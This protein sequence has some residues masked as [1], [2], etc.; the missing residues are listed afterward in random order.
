MKLE[1]IYI[2]VATPFNNG[3]IDLDGY[4]KYVESLIDSGIAGVVV[5][6]STGESSMLSMEE[7]V[8][9]LKFTKEFVNNRIQVI[10]NCGANSTS[11]AIYLTQEA[12][13]LEVD[14]VLS[15]VPYYVKPTQAG[16]YQHFKSI[17]DATEKVPIIIYNVP[18]RT[19]TDISVDTVAELAKLDRMIGIKE[20]SSDMEKVAEMVARTPEDFSVLS[21]NDAT[22]LPLLAVGGKGVIS[23]IGNIMPKE[24]VEL[25]NE[26]MAGDL[27]KAIAI[28]KRMIEMNKA[29]SL[30][31]NP[32]PVKYALYK[33]GHMNN[34]LR[35]PLT[36]MSEKN[37]ATMDQVL[38]ELKLI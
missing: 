10:A 6:G 32:I 21:G 27:K 20:A 4:K 16:L 19:I 35:L 24:L 33:T 12:E 18:G 29:L 8:E 9:L 30:E 36:P 25:Y 2:A 38:Q 1:G 34:E 5:C 15:V 7:H 28:N 17:Y 22:F 23:V 14:A 13:K 26:V 11:E 31:A 3:K 37:A